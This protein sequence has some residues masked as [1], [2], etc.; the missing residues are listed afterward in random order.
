MNNREIPTA[1]LILAMLLFLAIG[2]P[3]VLFD[4]LTLDQVLTG[5]LRPIPI[6]VASGLACVFLVGAALLGRYIARLVQ[7]GD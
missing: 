4:W 7:D 6:V 3:V 2:G 1:R 5:V